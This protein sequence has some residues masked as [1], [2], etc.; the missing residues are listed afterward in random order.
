[1]SADHVDPFAVEGVEAPAVQGSA[2]GAGDEPDPD[3]QPL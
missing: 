2:A 1:M 3:W